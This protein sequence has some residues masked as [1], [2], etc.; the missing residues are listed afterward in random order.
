MRT[1]KRKHIA[2]VP[3][4]L[5]FLVVLFLVYYESYTGNDWFHK[6]YPL[7]D[8]YIIVILAIFVISIICS[9]LF[10]RILAKIGYIFI[11][12]FIC[13]FLYIYFVMTFNL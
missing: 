9:F 3:I 1:I 12:L 5:Q 13:G 7:V 2:L 11:N 4:F 10:K 6:F 8:K